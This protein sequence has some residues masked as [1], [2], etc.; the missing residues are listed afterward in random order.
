MHGRSRVKPVRVSRRDA[1]E[2]TE[3]LLSNK[4]LRKQGPH[5]K[6]ARV[7]VRIFAFALL[8]NKIKQSQPAHSVVSEVNMTSS[9]VLGRDRDR[10][11]GELLAQLKAYTFR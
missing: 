6:H 9:V 1:G 8:A 7:L 5:Y 10:E 11:L 2:G 3:I 4:V